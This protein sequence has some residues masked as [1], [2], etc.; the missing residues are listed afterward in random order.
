V[1]GNLPVLGLAQELAVP[2]KGNI[3]FVGVATS[4]GQH[5][6]DRPI[7]TPVNDRHKMILRWTKSTRK[8]SVAI[9]APT[10]L[11][12]ANLFYLFGPVLATGCG[13]IDFALPMTLGTNKPV[14]GREEIT[15]RHAP[16]WVSAVA[17]YVVSVLC[18][19]IGKG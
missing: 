17:D 5:N 19:F 9:D 16:D 4:A 8:E 7:C 12:R 11:K 3:A 18:F 6:I 14:I 10:P 13:E 1:Q 2:L 15:N